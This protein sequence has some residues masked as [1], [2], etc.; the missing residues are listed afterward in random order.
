MPD[1]KIMT[2]LDT[3]DVAQ[4]A[5]IEAMRSLADSGKKTASAVESVQVEIRDVR[6]RLIRIEATEFKAE[7]G[8]AKREIERLRKEALS[9]MEATKRRVD[10]LEADKDRRDGGAA[11]AGAVLK[12]GPFVIALITALFVVL[13]ATRQ[14]KL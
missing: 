2:A 11:F 9:E 5:L 12:Y 3:T 1:G 7:I 6:E 10:V 8:Q 4:M 13:L 14:I